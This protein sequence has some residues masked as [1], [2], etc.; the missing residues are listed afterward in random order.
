VPFV[1]NKLLDNSSTR[2]L[3]KAKS[4]FL[5]RTNL[6]PSNIPF[7]SIAIIH[8]IVTTDLPS[9]SEACSGEIPE[10]SVVALDTNSFRSLYISYVGLRPN[11]VHNSLF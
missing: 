10:L 7:S 2:T 1:Y 5:S 4:T 6:K 8:S 9:E 3:S 11:P